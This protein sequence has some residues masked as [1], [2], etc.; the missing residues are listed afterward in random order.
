MPVRFVPVPSTTDEMRLQDFY[1]DPLS[2]LDTGKALGV[3]V[4]V[5]VS[6]GSLCT[7][8]QTPRRSTIITRYKYKWPRPAARELSI[9]S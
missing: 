4:K 9:W 1:R 8:Q 5:G 6:A 3:L 7:L 2:C